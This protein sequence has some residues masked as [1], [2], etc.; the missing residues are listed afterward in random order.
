MAGDVAMKPELQSRAG[1]LVLVGLMVLAVCACRAPE[2]PLRVGVLVWPPYDLAFLAADREFVDSD[3]IRLVTFHSPAELARSFRYGLLDAM[4]TTSHFVLTLSPDVEGVRVIYVIDASRGGDA[5][6]TKP[7]IDSAE[8]LIGRRIGVEAAPLGLYT[9]QRALNELELDRQDVNIVP[10]DTAEHFRAWHED[11]VDAVVTY[12]PTRTQ[13]KQSGAREL[14]NSRQIPDE[15]L[16]VLVVRQDT[17]E[18]RRD[19]LVGF[20]RGLDRALAAYRAD[21]QDA[22]S[23]MVQRHPISPA[24]F[25]LAME[26]V[27][28]FD[29][30]DNLQLLASEDGRL[31]A[32]LA[33]Q[34]KVMVSAGMLDE[35]PALDEAIDASIV[36]QAASR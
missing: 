32:A 19:S 24:E 8:D 34:C 3:D 35:A 12:E 2:P 22:V 6:L 27:E 9:L 7:E 16:D 14:F 15:I 23:A 5:L 4:F 20:V 31:S 36:E 25:T 30:S 21:P 11:R 28:L 1:R 29:L 33:K 17:I 10:I 26:G 18:A 13:L